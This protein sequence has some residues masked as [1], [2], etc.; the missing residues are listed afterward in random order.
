MIDT[1]D[2][3]PLLLCL[4]KLA[5]AF[6]R[7]CFLDI[8]SRSSLSRGDMF[9]QNIHYINLRATTARRSAFLFFDILLSHD[10]ALE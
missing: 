4:A 8:Y 10:Y 2:N 6:V 9:C 3:K 7:N 1:R 5:R